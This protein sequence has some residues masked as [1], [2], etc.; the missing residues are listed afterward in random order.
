MSVSLWNKTNR[1]FWVASGNSWL[2]PSPKFLYFLGRLF[3]VWFS[4]KCLK[5]MAPLLHGFKNWKRIEIPSPNRSVFFIFILFLNNHQSWHDIA[6]FAR[7]WFWSGRILARLIILH[8]TFLTNQ[9]N[10]CSSL[11]LEHLL[12]WLALRA[13]VRPNSCRILLLFLSQPSKGSW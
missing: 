2:R 1:V 9:R 4:W 5:R 10:T 11:Q 8:G 12:S 3:F 7:H 13:L 6:T